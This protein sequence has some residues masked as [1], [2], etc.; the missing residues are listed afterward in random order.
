MLWVSY[1]I[2]DKLA[3]KCADP[4]AEEKALVDWQA[5]NQQYFGQCNRVDNTHPDT[6]AQTFYLR[7]VTDSC[8]IQSYKVRRYMASCSAKR[9]HLSKA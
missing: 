4:F 1:V 2:L 3:L 6:L 5:C 9:K 7:P 8:C